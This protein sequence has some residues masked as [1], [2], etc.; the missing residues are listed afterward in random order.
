M[1]G[2][3]T[4]KKDKVGVE[5]VFSKMRRIFNHYLNEGEQQRK[6]TLL[7]FKADFEKKVQQAAQQQLNFGAARVDVE[8]TP[9][10][11]AEWRKL[12]LQLDESYLHYLEEFKRELAA[13]P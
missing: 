13:I 7:N 1:D 2:I 10:F 12:R 4:L 3:K 8:N 11:Q 5:N 6:R 9:Q